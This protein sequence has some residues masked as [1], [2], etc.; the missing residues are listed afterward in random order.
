MI[1]ARRVKDPGLNGLA[2]VGGVWIWRNA[3]SFVQK[4]VKGRAAE[5]VNLFRGVPRG[6]GSDWQGCQFLCPHARRSRCGGGAG[7]AAVMARDTQGT[8]T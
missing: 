8:A 6:W 7:A 3:G 2:G 4:P 1:Q 5:E